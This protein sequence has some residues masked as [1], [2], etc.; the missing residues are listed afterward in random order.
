MCDIR[1][2]IR[3]SCIAVTNNTDTD[4]ND[5]ERI[6]KKPVNAN[7]SSPLTA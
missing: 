4:V 5:T 6:Y 2:A 3:F 1:Q 7:H